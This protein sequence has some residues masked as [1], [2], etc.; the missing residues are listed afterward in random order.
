MEIQVCMHRVQNYHV[1]GKQLSTCKLMSYNLSHMD[2][3]SVTHVRLL[4]LYESRYQYLMSQVVLLLSC[5]MHMCI[6]LF[7]DLAVG[8]NVL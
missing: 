1:I 7:C 4:T 3:I 6:L 2:N 8:S 5:Y